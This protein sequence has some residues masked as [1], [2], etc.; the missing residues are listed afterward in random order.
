MPGTAGT[1]VF[2]TDTFGSADQINPRP[3][4]VAQHEETAR[5]SSVRQ[6]VRRSSTS[7]R[8]RSP[9]GWTSRSPR[10]TTGRPTF[11]AF[12]NSGTIKI[13][14]TSILAQQSYVDAVSA[15]LANFARNWQ[16]AT[17]SEVQHTM[18]NYRDQLLDSCWPV[19]LQ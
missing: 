11:D 10:T 3:D 4:Q 5:R 16:D 1:F 19:C 14:A 12:R 2:T 13:A 9:R 17:A 18:N 15:A 8:G 7:A 6:T